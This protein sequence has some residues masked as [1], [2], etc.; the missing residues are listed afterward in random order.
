[1]DSDVITILAKGQI[2]NLDKAYLCKQGTNYYTNGFEDLTKTATKL[3]AIVS[4]KTEKNM[5]VTLLPVTI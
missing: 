3:G 2:Y 5:L 4:Y 1:M